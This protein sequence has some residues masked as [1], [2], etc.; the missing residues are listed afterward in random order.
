MALRPTAGFANANRAAPFGLEELRTKAATTALTNLYP[1]VVCDSIVSRVRPILPV[2]DRAASKD[3][4]TLLGA[5]T[6]LEAKAD[7]S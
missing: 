6:N 4:A 1:R 7:K 5:S 3:L 2:T